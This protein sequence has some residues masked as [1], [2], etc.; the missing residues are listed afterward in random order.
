[1]QDDDKFTLWNTSITLQ[2]HLFRYL[3]PWIQDNN[4]KK[5]ILHEIMN[6][7]VFKVLQNVK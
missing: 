2:N 6:I 4:P 7:L 3:F 5:G 1:M